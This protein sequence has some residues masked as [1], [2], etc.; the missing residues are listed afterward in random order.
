M[1][2][3]VSIQSRVGRQHVF[4]HG[5]VYLWILR[6]RTVRT[7]REDP[8]TSMFPWPMR[9]SIGCEKSLRPR[10]HVR[11]I[12][13]GVKKVSMIHNTYSLM[14]EVCIYN[15]RPTIIVH[16]KIDSEQCGIGDTPHTKIWYLTVCT[17]GDFLHVRP[18]W[19]F[20]MHILFGTRSILTSL[21]I[22]S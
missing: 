18:G 13:M 21:M 9:E 8:C 6:A 11:R 16:R 10:A 7:V 4:T 12:P 15:H 22:I 19:T 20:W 5:V 17:A 2:C 3:C 1:L 14:Y